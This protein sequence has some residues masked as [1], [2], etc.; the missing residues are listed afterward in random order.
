L[1]VK[2]QLQNWGNA[3]A[4]HPGFAVLRQRLLDEGVLGGLNSAELSRTYNLLRRL[5]FSREAEEVWPVVMS[6]LGGKKMATVP[7]LLGVWSIAPVEGLPHVEAPLARAMAST[8]PPKTWQLLSA[9]SRASDR[10]GSEVVRLC[11]RLLG[12]RLADM[13]SDDLALIVGQFGSRLGAAGARVPDQLQDLAAKAK[14]ELIARDGALEPMQLCGLLGSIRSQ[15]DALWPMAKRQLVAKSNSLTAP[16]IL[17]VAQCIKRLGGS[18]AE[19]ALFASVTKPL[20]KQLSSVRQPFLVA[21]VARNLDALVTDYYTCLQLLNAAVRLRQDLY[22]VVLWRLFVHTSEAEL[23]RHH[24]NLQVRMQKI[25]E[26]LEKHGL[27]SKRTTLSEMRDIAKAMRGN[28]VALPVCLAEMTKRFLDVLQTVEENFQQG[29]DAAQSDTAASVS[30]AVGDASLD[31]DT[32]RETNWLGEV[33]ELIVSFWIQLHLLG[34]DQPTLTSAM[35]AFCAAGG[36]CQI[37]AEALAQSVLELERIKDTKA[38]PFLAGLTGHLAGRFDKMKQQSFIQLAGQASSDVLRRAVVVEVDR[39][40]TRTR[41]AKIG[42]LK[43]GQD[44]DDLVFLLTRWLDWSR[45]AAAQKRDGPPLVPPELVHRIGS[46]LAES[47]PVMLQKEP[48]AANQRLADTL[49]AL[50]AFEPGGGGDMGQWER[51]M[52]QHIGALSGWKPASAT[53]LAFSYTAIHSGA[54]PF[55]TA[56]RLFRLVGSAL[57]H[58]TKDPEGLSQVQ[59]AKLWAFWL[60][61]RHL[62]THTVFATLRL[63]PEA[64]TIE[65][66]LRSAETKAA[67]A[68]FE[69]AQDASAAAALAWLRAALPQAAPQETCEERFAV[70]GTPYVADFGIQKRRLLLVVPRRDHRAPDRPELSGPGRLM[71]RTLAAMGWQTQWVWPERWPAD[72]ADDGGEPVAEALRQLLGLGAAAEGGQERREG[73]PPETAPP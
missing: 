1:G 62:S 33:Q 47:L 22:P 9:V 26:I 6:H 61:L 15:D 71:E 42:I 45:A 14:A 40:I 36:A 24:P 16:Q 70:P 64:P 5:N 55:D 39:R 19:P 38:E 23:V 50:S 8:E 52:S 43:N 44:Y 35:E 11:A 31:T 7:E 48:A 69:L 4:K 27:A 57:R 37:G 2:Q 60:A 58:V 66:L 29:Q 54:L 56:L 25:G 46:L 72:P 28:R 49:A 53:D 51:I 68:R 17:E 13:S 63:A 20:Q 10:P 41:S 59:T 30:G 73:H 32:G 12:G 3:C 18:D 65:S 21:V 34:T 67:P